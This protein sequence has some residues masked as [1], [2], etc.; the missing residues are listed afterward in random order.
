MTIYSQL[1]IA[2]KDSAIIKKDSFVAHISLVPIQDTIFIVLDSVNSKYK[3][4]KIIIPDTRKLDTVKYKLYDGNGDYVTSNLNYA[5]VNNL[6]SWVFNNDKEAINAGLK[7]GQM[8][9]LTETNTYNFPK[10][11]VK[12]VGTKPTSTIKELKNN[13]K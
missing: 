7:Y 11:S 2:Q 10:N 4:A 12:I 6:K 13:K 1:S 8:Y 5:T 3:F 9:I